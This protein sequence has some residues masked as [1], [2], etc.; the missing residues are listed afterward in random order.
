MIQHVYERAR[1]ASCL[2]R[3]VVATDDVRILEVVSGFGGECVLTRSDHPSGT[4]RLAE[5][6]DLCELDPEDLI[7]N[8]QGDEPLV[9][10]RMIEALVDALVTHP[11]ARMATLAFPGVSEREYLD[12]N[13]VKV[14]VDG[15]W[16]ALYFSRAPIPHDRDRTHQSPRFL[17]HLGFYAYRLAFLKELTLLPQ[18]PLERI[19]KLEQLRALEHGYAIQVALSPVETMG[20]DT[21]DDLKRIRRMPASGN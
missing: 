6:G 14:V 21:P 1:S 10:P 8:I 18:S 3:L 20:V 17:K 5:A 16:R 15:A 13:V 7:V 11:V 19:E 12:P 4:D 9:S 2:H